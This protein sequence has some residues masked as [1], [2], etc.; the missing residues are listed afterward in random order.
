MRKQQSMIDIL[1]TVSIDNQPNPIATLH[2]LIVSLG[3]IGNSQSQT[4]HMSCIQLNHHYHT[5]IQPSI[6]D[7]VVELLSQVRLSSLLQ[8]KLQFHLCIHLF[9]LSYAKLNCK[10][11]ILGSHFATN[12]GQL[13]WSYA[14]K[15]AHSSY[16]LLHTQ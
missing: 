10:C 13:G 6:G 2:S 3:Y 12:D 11:I 9:L 16:S 15:G 1:F 7:L 5:I 8:T 14:I 4:Y